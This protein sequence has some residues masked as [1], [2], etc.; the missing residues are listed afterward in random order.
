MPPARPDPARDPE[1][2][3]A[4]ILPYDESEPPSSCSGSR[5]Y[6]R[7]DEL[8]ALLQ[9]AEEAKR[10][11]IL[12]VLGSIEPDRRDFLSLLTT[13]PT[14]RGNRRISTSNGHRAP[15]SHATATTLKARRL[16]I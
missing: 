9:A 15:D 3:R 8:S 7:E 11:V 4:E 12:C 13:F 1:Q 14:D 16:P 2:I 5:K 6:L 10:V